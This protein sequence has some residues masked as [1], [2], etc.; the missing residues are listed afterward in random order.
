MNSWDKYFID[1]AA[2]VAQKSKDRSRKVG[3]VIVGPDNEVRSTGFNGFPRAV[4]EN[5][6]D[7]ESKF[8]GVNYIS[9]RGPEYH[10]REEQINQNAN[11][12]SRHERPAKY[13]WTEH[14]ERNAIYNA[15]R[16]GIS[17][18]GCRLYLNF[19]PIPCSDCA[20]GII[21]SGIVSVIGPNISFTSKTLEQNQMNWDDDFKVTKQMFSEAQISMVIIP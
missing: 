7:D 20:R 17:L 21:Q 13:K 16:I 12:K 8:F 9:E 4:Y 18:N 1:M 10:S 11:I 3:A 19:E 5:F 15:A 6:T 2:F 14:A